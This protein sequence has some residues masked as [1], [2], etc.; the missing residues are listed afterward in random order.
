MT[1]NCSNIKGVR[2]AQSDIHG[3][4]AKG[5][6]PIGC[7]KGWTLPAW[8]TRKCSHSHNGV[9]V[10]NPTSSNG[11]GTGWITNTDSNTGDKQGWSNGSNGS[12][13]GHSGGWVTQTQVQNS[14]AEVC[15]S[16]TSSGW[17]DT[18]RCSD[19][20][21]HKNGVT[22]AHVSKDSIDHGKDRVMTKNCS[23]IK[24]VREAQS[25]IHGVSAKGVIPIGCGKGW[26]LPA[27]TT[28]KCSHSHNG[29]EV[30]N[31]TSSNGGGT[32]WITNTDS[33]TGDKQGWSNGSNGSGWGH[34][35]GWVT[36]TQVQNSD[37]EVWASSTSSGWDNTRLEELA[38]YID[39]SAKGQH[40]WDDRYS[41][42]V[43]QG[44]EVATEGCNDGRLN[45]KCS[46]SPVIFPERHVNHLRY[47]SPEMV[48]S[49][50]IVPVYRQ[51]I[52]E[53]FLRYKFGNRLIVVEETLTSKTLISKNRMIGDKYCELMGTKL[54]KNK[55]KGNFFKQGMYGGQYV[56]LY[57]YVTRASGLNFR[58]IQNEL[59]KIANFKAL[60]P[61]KVISRIELLMSTA[62]W[63]STKKKSPYTF[64][65][66]LPSFEE[67][68][69]RHNVGCGFIPPKMLEYMLGGL[70]GV[71]V[72]QVRI[73]GASLGIFKGVL[74]KKPGIDKIQLPSSMKKVNKSQVTVSDI[75]YV[76]FT[77][78]FP[79]KKCEMIGRSINPRLNDPPESAVGDLKNGR[80][81][82]PMQQQLLLGTGVPEGILQDYVEKS[83]TRFTDCNHATCMGVC[84]F[85]GCLP[86]GTI[87]LSGFGVGGV[88]KEI[89]ISCCLCTEI[90]D[91]K[92]LKLVTEQP[93][94]MSDAN[95]ELLSTM[96]FGIVV[97]A[98][99][100][101]PLAKTMPEQMADG[102]L[103]GDWYFVCWNLEILQSIDHNRLI[104]SKSIAE[105][106][107]S[108]EFICKDA[109]DPLI[110]ATFKW[111]N[112][113]ALIYARCPDGAYWVKIG[114]ES[115]ML[116][117][118]EIQVEN[119]LQFVDKIMTHTGSGKKC[120]IEVLWGNTV[121][122]QELLCEKKEEMSEMLVDYAVK[123]DLLGE[124]D[125]AW[126]K[127]LIRDSVPVKIENHRGHDESI[128]FEVRFDDGDIIWKQREDID[129]D[130]L[131]AYASEQGILEEPEW[132][133]LKS[134]ME[135]A[136][137]NW[138]DV[139]QNQMADANLLRDH[140]N[141]LKILHKEHAKIQDVNDTDSR[142]FGHAYK[143]ATDLHKHSGHVRLPAH[144]QKA[145]SK[146][147]F[148]YIEFFTPSKVSLDS[149]ATE[150][151]LGLLSEANV[152][153]GI[154]RGDDAELTSDEL[155][156]LTCDQLRQ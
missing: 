150:E 27:W 84:D 75:V 122:T 32:G 134:E 96:K 60:P 94:A 123:N 6:I 86:E 55:A 109:E 101:D 104:H 155:Q 34:S 1:K 71:D 93:K 61:E 15:A 98:S 137:K 8:T 152:C 70:T 81:V 53:Y 103:D 80:G 140:S 110:N 66:E 136:D 149:S 39:G 119:Q 43:N 139:A 99:P 113:E 127:K 77:Q 24:G 154:S 151:S 69:E 38:S 14:D 56:K 36:Q 67:I 62:A 133:W 129:R 102:D 45:Q 88:S 92:V 4:S 120:E 97:F 54:E 105:E 116:T 90:N 135:I 29:V 73:V 12:G 144:L 23:N 125:W 33:N 19:G 85:T 126:C 87:F 20:A 30:V 63:T 76:I 124:R 57:Y 49:K 37:A 28:R 42:S 25:D 72:V 31:P 64:H 131:V 138:F 106:E 26:T 46:D 21:S 100:D 2:E 141:M 118:E 78:L 117:K 7:G 143:Q 44:T 65:L 128:E 18:G 148:K 111:K 59:E 95:W 48:Q 47:S 107:E 5:V 52:D 112:Q 130:L 114:T 108:N 3:V 142:Y 147:L 89:F 83:K 82:P 22:Q 115:K 50:Y 153:A 132:Q 10:V 9:E 35:G 146:D 11:G 68:P 41:S 13:W 91:G 121:V 16:S 156:G 145:V 74:V 40:I 17:D 58:N 51:T 79:S